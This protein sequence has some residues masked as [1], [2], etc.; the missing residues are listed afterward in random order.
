MH[1]FDPSADHL[2]AALPDV[3]WLATEAEFYALGADLFHLAMH[4]EHR[5]RAFD[6]LLDRSHR[7]P[8]TIL[9]E[10]PMAAPEDP[11]KCWAIRQAIDRAR[12]VV[13]YD[14]PELY[15]PLLGRIMQFLRGF[16]DVRIDSIDVQRSK[17]REDPA[18][19]RNRKRMVS[20]QFQESVHCLAFALHVLS[21][22]AGGVEALLNQGCS[23][24]GTSRIY[25]PPNPED[26]PYAVDG[27]CE[28]QALLGTTVVKGCTNFLRGAPWAKRRVLRGTG[29]GQAF[30]IVADFL[31]GAKQLLINGESQSDVLGTDSYEEVIKT[32]GTWCR[33]ETAES[34]PR[35]L[36]P[37]PR[38]AH[39]TYQLSSMLW[40]SCHDQQSLHRA[41]LADV[42]SFDAMFAAAVPSLPRYA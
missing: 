26:Y 13:L 37:H 5:D 22:F 31:E 23:L 17:D 11:E 6:T 30:T 19:P 40:R 39:V 14:F 32:C 15:D 38:F 28:Y 12:A 4:P 33:Q 16:K 7:E 24:E 41:T 18:N 8:I 21:A 1:A 25:R 35:G 27:Y 36:Y 9:C 2:K 3:H 42:M 10:K 29:D 20:I 34:L